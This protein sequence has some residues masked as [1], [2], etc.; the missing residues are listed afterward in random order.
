MIRVVRPQQKT[1]DAP[2]GAAA[3]RASRTPSPVRERGRGEGPLLAPEVLINLH[4]I[5]ALDPCNSRRDDADGPSIRTLALDLI[6]HG[7]AHPLLVRWFT[8]KYIVLAGGRRWRALIMAQE[9]VDADPS[10][11]EGAGLEFPIRVR[12]RVFNG[13]DDAARELSLAENFQ[14]NDLTPLDEAERFA[15]LAARESLPRIARRFGVNERFLHERLK[16]ANLPGVA[17]AAWR[18]LKFGLETARALTIGT[19]ERITQL[20]ETKPELLA[21]PASVREELRPKGLPAS[22]P[23][24][25]FVGADDFIAA[26][27]VIFQDL[28][29]GEAIYQDS[30]LVDRL[31]SQKLAQLGEKICDEEGWGHVFIAPAG[32]GLPAKKLDFTADENLED[33]EVLSKLQPLPI[34]DAAAEELEARQDELFRRAALRTVAVDERKYFAIRLDLD[35]IGH[36]LIERALALPPPGLGRWREA[37]ATDRGRRDEGAPRFAPVPR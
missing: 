24:A 26:G 22:A 35:E 27:G 14:R 32:A 23:K 33:L 19:P 34:G 12:V 18:A 28:F 29:G 30:A 10:L 7:Q 3:P 2:D 36:P 20:V 17:K 31:A 8:G 11:A 13:D 6:A 9:L 25:R 15:E 21:S 37:E 5:I 4:E 1:F 16:L